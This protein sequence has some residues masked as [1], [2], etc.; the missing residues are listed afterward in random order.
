M[1]YLNNST[2]G[3]TTGNVTLN[4]TNLPPHTHSATAQTTTTVTS[5]QFVNT[6]TFAEYDGSKGVLGNSAAQLGSDIQISV[7]T[8]TITTIG[9]NNGSLTTPFSSNPFSITPPY[10][11]VAYYIK[12]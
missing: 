9:N 4:E 3:V 11:V 5:P 2:G 10:T 8:N 12:R 1:T 6:P 7:T